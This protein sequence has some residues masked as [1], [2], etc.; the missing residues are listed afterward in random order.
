MFY[1]VFPGNQ[2]CVV[3]WQWSRTYLSPGKSLTFWRTSTYIRPL[4]RQAKFSVS[5]PPTIL[6]S[7]LLGKELQCTKV[8]LPVQYFTYGNFS[9]PLLTGDVRWSRLF[10]SPHVKCFIISVVL[11][12]QYIEASWERLVKRNVNVTCRI[13]PIRRPVQYF[14]QI[15]FLSDHFFPN[16]LVHYIVKKIERLPSGII[17]TSEDVEIYFSPSRSY[18]GKYFGPVIIMK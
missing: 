6:F 15:M 5:Y 9:R 17:Y 8:S 16:H 10:V 13:P 18:K 2:L 14:K 7:I 1:H 4:E 3:S 11:K 12:L